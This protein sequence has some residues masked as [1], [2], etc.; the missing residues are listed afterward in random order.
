MKML[1]Y[2]FDK[3]LKILKRTLSENEVGTPTE[4]YDVLKEVWGNIRK[5][6]GEVANVSS[7]PGVVPTSYK[8]ITLRYQKDL[9]Y[10]CRIQYENDTY[11]ID[12]IE[13]IGRKEGL[14]LQCIVWNEEK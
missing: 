13:E 2:L 8:E 12:D 1:S 10:D 6:R 4:N 3:R 11:I 5:K 14:R 7:V 9:G